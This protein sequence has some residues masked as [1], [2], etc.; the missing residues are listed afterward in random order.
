MQDQWT[1]TC[2]A[3]GHKHARPM[4]TNMHDQWTQTCMTNGHKHARQKEGTSLAK[5]GVLLQQKNMQTSTDE[6]RTPKE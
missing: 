4:D 1:Q 6:C 2:K 5:E 3:K